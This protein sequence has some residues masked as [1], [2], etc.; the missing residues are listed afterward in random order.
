M[1]GIS[2]MIERAAADAES[3][4]GGS[5]QIRGQRRAGAETPVVLSVRLTAEQL[6]KL[7]ARAEAAGQPTSAFAR[8]ILLDALG[9][10]ERD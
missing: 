9:E 1:S 10:S 5:G 3:H 4:Q 7:S 6:A 2:E 8:G